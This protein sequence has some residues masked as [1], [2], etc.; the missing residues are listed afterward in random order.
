MGEA[1]AE[2]M[3][4]DGDGVDDNV[5]F[6]PAHANVGLAA[7]DIAPRRYAAGEFMEELLANPGT[8]SAPIRQRL[9]GIITKTARPNTTA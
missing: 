1:H 7:G 6:Y 3:D 5:D 9:E 2:S 8:P 4:S